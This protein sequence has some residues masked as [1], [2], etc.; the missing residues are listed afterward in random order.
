MATYSHDPGWEDIIPLPQDDGDNPLAQIAYTEEYSE[1]MSYLRAIMA[2]EEISDRALKITEHIIKINPAHYTVWLYRAMVIFE[3]SYDLR[4]E[5]HFLNEQAIW[6]EKNYQIWHHRQLVIDRLGDPTGETEF[7]GKMFDKDS[8][9]YHVWSYRQ[10]LVRRFDLWERGEIEYTT[11]LLHKDVRNNSA[12]NHRFF[13]IFG[14][15]DTVSEDVYERETKFIEECI[16][17]APQ[18][19]SPWN[20]LRGML[21]RMNKPLSAIEVLC[22]HY[23]PIGNPDSVL[24]SHALDLLADIWAETPGTKD[25]AVK[26]LELLSQKYDPIR[27]NYWNHRRVL[28]QRTA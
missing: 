4:D 24:S 6:H 11:L 8:K 27:A 26:A 13:L 9:N 7:I 3:L 5:I 14:R 21:S 17:L 12:W 22:T 23:A 15:V 10:W 1:A 25:N 28:L 16:F 18:N 20:Y 2:K 19:P